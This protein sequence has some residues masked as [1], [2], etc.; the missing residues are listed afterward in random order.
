MGAV[1]ALTHYTAPRRRGRLRVRVSREGWGGP[2]P[3]GRVTVSIG[4]LGDL[5][6][7]PAISYVTAQK[8]WT[9]R[10][11]T[12]RTFTFRTPTVPYRLQVHVEPTFSPADYGYGDT[13]RLGAQVQ[14][15]SVG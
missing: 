9:V 15:E 14:I 7:Y 10:S 1:A 11:R 12:A 13:R 5:N 2:S 4:L 8:R 3:P 6:G